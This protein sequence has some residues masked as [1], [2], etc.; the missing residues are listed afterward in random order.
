M[1]FFKRLLYLFLILFLLL[2]IIAAFHAWKFTH[3]Y[4]AG[5]YNNKKPE[6][7]TA[8][9]K[10][11]TILFGV[12]LSK[13]VVKLKPAVPYETVILHTANGLKLEGW[14]MPIPK[15]SGTVIL[16]HG[17]GETK[18]SKLS[19]ASYFR[20]LGYNTFL[21]DFRAHGNS[22]GYT[23]TVGF[24][25]AEDV[26]LAY[27]YIQHKN[28]N[29]IVLWGMSMGAAAVLRA[30]TAYDLHPDKIILECCF[31]TLTDAVK[32]RM[33]AVHIPVTPFSQI[34]TFWGGVEHGFWGPGYN[35]EA[36]AREMK[37][38]A[39]ICW[40]AHDFRVYRQE[41]DLIYQHL[42]SKKKQLLVFNESAHQ[43]FCSNEPVKWKNAVKKFMQ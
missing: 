31:A 19:E 32:A 5:I 27:Q 39:L 1:K 37:M 17:Y 33:R 10:T 23:C 42:G 12:H 2:N 28:E 41:T 16:F 36:Y 20:Q 3:F 15:A 18:A 25:E 13:S 26:K 22:D 7:M 38:P 34:L 24:N 11:K 40:G 21:I 4:P 43:S 14:W 9:E 8:W 29:H 6:Q 35:P 30:I